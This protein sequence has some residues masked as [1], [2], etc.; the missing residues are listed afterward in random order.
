MFQALKA[1][2]SNSAQTRV[3]T[4][5]S[6]GRTVS[7]VNV[8]ATKKYNSKKAKKKVKKLHEDNRQD[9]LKQG[10]R[11]VRRQKGMKR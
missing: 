5:S 7:N 11:N 4:I 3:R 8:K 10:G 9:N 1:V 6:K 2:R